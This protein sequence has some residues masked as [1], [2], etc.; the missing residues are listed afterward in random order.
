MCINFVFP[1]QETTTPLAV[2]NDIHLLS[3]ISIGQKSRYR[4]A[5]P[6]PLLRLTRPKSR[7]E[8]GHI[9]YWRLWGRTRFQVHAGCWQ[10]LILAS[11][12]WRRLF[13]C[14]LPPGTLAPRGLSLVLARGLLLLRASS[15]IYVESISYLECF[16]TFSSA[17]SL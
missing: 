2:K 8:Q 10:N 4:V 1:M 15:T 7:Y 9:P 3:H 17:I 11:V 6:G 16:L 14:W 13:P 12:G 5:Q